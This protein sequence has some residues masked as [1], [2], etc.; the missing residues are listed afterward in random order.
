MRITYNKDAQPARC[1]ELA[2]LP[3]NVLELEGTIM[4][5]ATLP[6]HKRFRNLTGQKFGQLK[7]LSFIGMRRNGAFWLC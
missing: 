7:V 3:Q 4:A 6:T 2:A 5:S 1:N